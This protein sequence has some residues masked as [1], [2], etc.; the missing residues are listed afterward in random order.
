MSNFGKYISNMS[1]SDMIELIG[2]GAVKKL[3]ESYSKPA[4]SKGLEGNNFMDMLKQINSYDNKCELVIMRVFDSTSLCPF[5]IAIGD[6]S[7]WYFDHEPR[8]SHY[9]KLRELKINLTFVD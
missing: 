1:V 7:Y 4:A 5:G 9:E 2:A 3:I 6:K 8:E